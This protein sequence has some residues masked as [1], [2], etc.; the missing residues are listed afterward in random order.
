MI[1]EHEI[2]S[3]DFSQGLGETIAKARCLSSLCGYVD[4]S[5]DDTLT[6][7]LM[8]GLSSFLW[9]IGE[10]LDQIYNALY[11]KDKKGIDNE[12]DPED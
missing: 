1:H 7:D 8:K 5:E 6:I 9:E 3:K 4:R 10:D 11:L 2:G 12:N